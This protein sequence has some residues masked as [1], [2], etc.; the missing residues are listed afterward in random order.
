MLPYFRYTVPDDMRTHRIGCKERKGRSSPDT[1][2]LLSSVHNHFNK[3]VSKTVVCESTF[4]SCN[5]IPETKAKEETF[6][7]L[8]VSEILVHGGLTLL[9]WACG[10]AEQGRTKFI[11]VEKKRGDLRVS[12]STSRVFL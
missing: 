10:K 1:H 11:A 6:T 2:L 7:W 4:C 5:K 12:I 9:L 3:L 8:T